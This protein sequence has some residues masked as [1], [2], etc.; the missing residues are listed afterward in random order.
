MAELKDILDNVT[1]EDV[2]D[3]EG[4]DYKLGHGS[5][6]EQL[7]IHQCPFCGGSEWKVYANRD[8]GLGNCFHGSCGTT[9]N[10]FTFTRALLDQDNRSTITYLEKMAEQAGWRPKKRVE[11]QTEVYAN[12]DWQ[13]PDSYPLPTTDGQNL[14]YLLERRVDNDTAALF[15]LRYCDDGWF[16]Y[17]KPDGSRGGM[18]FAQRVIIPVFDID[19][20][21]VTFQGRD[22][23]GESDRK[24]LFPP[25]LP[26]TGRFLFNGQNAAGKGTVIVCE[27]AFDVIRTYVNTRGTDYDRAGVVGTFGIDL[28]SGQDGGDQKNRFLRLK[29]QGL[30]RVIMFWDGEPTAFRKSLKAAMTLKK[31]GL[32]VWVAKPPAG[33]DP[34][35]LDAAETITAL[36]AAIR[37]DARTALIARLG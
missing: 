16:N 25:G 32:D 17:T 22:I 15:H 14:R 35:E 30:S 34:G 4:A 12:E 5:S 20:V 36:N 23:T 33:K 27:G 10:I 13:L 21:M 29:K 1:L 28:S 7:N 2:L 37:V 8:S 19:G 6:G 18:N 9:F 11:I 26:G 31:L 3:R 24:Y